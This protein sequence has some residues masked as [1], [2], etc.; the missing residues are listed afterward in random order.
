M[1]RC[2]FT[3]LEN[4]VISELKK[5]KKSVKAAVAWINFNT[6]G[7]VFEELINQGVRIKII[8]NKDGINL[9]YEN[10]I[11]YLNKKGANIRLVDFGGIM[12][13]KFCIIDKYLCMFG[14]FN[15]TQSANKRNIENLNIS[16]ETIIVKNYLLE[17]QAIWDLKKSDIQLLTHPP[18][19]NVCRKPIINILF[20]EQEGDC[21]TKIDILQQCY[22]MQKIIY[23]DYYDADI[24]NNYIGLIQ[25]NRDEIWNESEFY[26]EDT[27]HRMVVWREYKI[28][29]YLTFVRRIRMG[30]PI[31]HA[32]GVKIWEH[33]DKHDG[34]WVYKIIWKER[35]TDDYI[36]DEYEI[37]R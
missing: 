6:Y 24:Y 36:D 18:C 22:C 10:Y 33:I 3:N 12:H 32:V 25:N 1:N 13:H 21:Q 20:M 16:N 30:I 19:C 35:G 29:K 9:R 8:L 34:E 15:W 26:D 14:S 28:A 27:Y 4:I 17:F 23:T 37:I 31:I 5:A 2:Y 7:Y 11:K